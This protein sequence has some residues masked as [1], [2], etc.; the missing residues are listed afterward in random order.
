[1]STPGFYVNATGSFPWVMT[2]DA[3][4]FR[5]FWGP[6]LSDGE[7][8]RFAMQAG[9][10]EVLINQSIIDPTNPQQFFGCIGEG[11]F[12]QVAGNSRILVPELLTRLG[13]NI[14]TIPSGAMEVLI[15]AHAISGGHYTQNG[16]GRRLTPERWPDLV[17]LHGGTAFLRNW[18]HWSHGFQPEWRE[19]VGVDCMVFIHVATQLNLGLTERTGINHAGS[20]SNMWNNVLNDQARIADR[21]HILDDGTEWDARWF[22]LDANGNVLPFGV[23]GPAQHSTQW[24]PF[25]RPGDIVV[26]R[27]HGEIFFGFNQTNESVTIHAHESLFQVRGEARDWTAPPGRFFWIGSSGTGNKSGIHRWTTWMSTTDH[28][29]RN[30]GSNDTT[31]STIRVWRI[32]SALTPAERNQAGI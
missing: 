6:T 30:W 1:M 9:M 19:S 8:I 15:A 28:R 11:G 27:G 13:Y 23:Q 18:S 17:D 16:F 3:V 10:T 32:G 24:E 5:N 26:A 21:I 2:G 12:S 31:P 29:V 14:Q 4:G 20:S 7:F 22:A 25:L